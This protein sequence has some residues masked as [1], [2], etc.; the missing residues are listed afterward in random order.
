MANNPTIYLSVLTSR[1]SP[2]IK[3][4]RM[5]TKHK[6]HHVAVTYMAEYSDE[7]AACLP[8]LYRALERKKKDVV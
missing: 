3:E 8:N 2:K 6:G 4:I 7:I 5:T 1:A